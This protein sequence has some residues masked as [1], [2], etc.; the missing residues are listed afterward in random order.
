MALEPVGVD[1][2]RRRLAV[3][4]VLAAA[5]LVSGCGGAGSGSDAGS[6]PP[7]Q[8]FVSRPDLR[9]VPLSVLT[10]ARGT[11]PGYVFV[12]PK[13]DVDQAGPLI[14][15]DRGRVVW[16]RPLQTHGVTDF[17]VQS[18][19]GKHVLTWWQGQSAK[20]IGN[21]HYVIVDD[22]YRQIATVRA[23]NGLEGDIH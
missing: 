22:R 9:P 18:Y 17:R 2:A 20:G 12:A 15:D 16:F 8:H 19:R 23:G 5:G 4:L 14:V 11:A 6:P 7:S 21:G 13:K 3:V 10:P 1:L